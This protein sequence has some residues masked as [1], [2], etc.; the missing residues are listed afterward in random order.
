[1][2]PRP[3]SRPPPP[4]QAVRLIETHAGGPARAHRLGLALHC[5]ASLYALRSEAERASLELQLG[6]RVTEEAGGSFVL[7]EGLFRRAA[8]LLG[9][10][11]VLSGAPQVMPTH[12]QGGRRAQRAAWGKWAQTPDLLVRLRSGR[13]WCW[14]RLDQLV[15]LLP[16]L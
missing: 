4:T 7:A 2:P 11:L 15:G 5:L 12:S 16:P 1:M 14:G 13:L 9:A 6:E 10:P 3:H 8:H